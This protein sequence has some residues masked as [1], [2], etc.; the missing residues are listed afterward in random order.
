M[1]EYLVENGSGN[2]P[3][4]AAWRFAHS[5]YFR[6]L[7]MKQESNYP[8][9]DH[10]TLGFSA[11]EDRLL[12]STQRGQFGA[13]TLLLTRRMTVLVIRQLLSKLPDLSGLEK[14]PHAY[15][16]EVL[17]MAHQRAL[18][19]QASSVAK[20]AAP[21]SAAAAAVEES[22]G[23]SEDSGQSTDEPDLYLATE[24]TSELRE[25]R[26]LLAF[27]G[28]PLPKAMHTSCSH[29]PV[30][31]FT[32][33]PEQVH[34]FLELIIV[35]STEAQWHLPLDLPWLEPVNAGVS[36]KTISH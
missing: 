25:K 19:E 2:L 15:W 20:E 11:Y 30:V 3:K 10:F 12:L 7:S 16:Q 34:Q 5:E 27:K 22:A 35:K 4:K 26:L 21:D 1:I 24:I 18:A 32:L 36:A 9:S 14:T 17:Q 13:A 8:L 23:G 33:E 29:E 31:A 6:V 28:L